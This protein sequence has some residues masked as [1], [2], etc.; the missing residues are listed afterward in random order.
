MPV[1][2][3]F[4]SIYPKHSELIL[5]IMDTQIFDW[6]MNE[7]T[8]EWMNK[9]ILKHIK[10]WELLEVDAGEITNHKSREQGA[11]VVRSEEGPVR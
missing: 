7:W 5:H 8:N 11:D 4:T 6:R 2:I 3:L 1:F 9:W 10:V